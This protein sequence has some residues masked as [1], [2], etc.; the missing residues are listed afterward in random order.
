MRLAHALRQVSNDA[1]RVLV[2]E[3]EQ[4]GRM[5]GGWLK[6]QAGT[7]EVGGNGAL[8]SRSA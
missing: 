1:Y 7:G 2:E 3:V 8:T 5:I 6:T 4:V